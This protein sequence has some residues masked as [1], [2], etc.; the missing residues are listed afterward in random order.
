MGGKRSQVKAVNGAATAFQHDATVQ[1]NGTITLFDNG[2]VPKVHPQSRAI[3][4]SVNAHARTDTLL[5]RYEHSRGL[6]S[7]SQGS[8][9]T[10]PG[11]DVFVGWGAEPYFSEF[12][13]AGQ[14]LYDAHWHGSYQ[15][16]RAYRFPWTGTP[17]SPPSIAASAPSLSSPV[18]VYASWNGATGVASWRVLAG[19]SPTQLTPVANAAKSGFET[20]IVTPGPETYV[21]VQALNDAGTVLGTSATLKD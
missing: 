12:S 9:Q 2:A 5:A 16:Y 4:V 17:A 19:P 3:V 6:S 13:S 11:G 8:M 7:S 18:S 1:A 20:T 21:A 10:L 15:S 14:L